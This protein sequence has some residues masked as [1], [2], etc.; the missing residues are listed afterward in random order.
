MKKGA[1]IMNC[2]SVLHCMILIRPGDGKIMKKLL[3]SSVLLLM[4]AIVSQPSMAADL[5]QWKMTLQQNNQGQPMRLPSALH[6]DPVLERYYVVDSGGDSIQAF[7][8]DGA[9]YK[10]FTADGQLLVPF[11]LVR[12]KGYMWIVEKGKNSLTKI[13][14]EGRKIFPNSLFYNDKL[15][16][17]DRLEIYKNNLY[18]LDKLTGSIFVLDKNLNINSRFSC[19]ECSGGFVDFKLRN[20]SLWALEQ[21]SRTVYRFALDG[22][23]QDAIQLEK[24]VLDF[25]RAIE[26]DENGFL[27][28]LDRHKGS[29]FVFGVKGG[30]RYSFLEAGLARGQTYYPIALKFDPWK[31]LCVVDEG[32]GRVQIFSRK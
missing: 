31:N 2:K 5:W 30:F 28:I 32:N 17:P 21:A 9:F 26:V 11:D 13:D 29:I 3:L 19:G 10:G 24:K 14:I 20:G 15:I 23:L 12:G 8:R 18:V 27:Y 16:Y 6:I 1:K 25:P 22:T 7:T 4:V